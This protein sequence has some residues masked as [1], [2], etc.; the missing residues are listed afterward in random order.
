MLRVDGMH[1]SHD[2]SAVLRQ[3]HEFDQASKSYGAAILS[4]ERF[5]RWITARG[6]DM[7][8]VEAR[9]DP[10]AFGKTSPISYFSANFVKLLED[11]AAVLT[12]HFFCGQHSASNDKLCGPRGLIRSLQAQLV[13]KWP[14]DAPTDGINITEELD[15][16]HETFQTE[17]FC[18]LFETMLA[19]IPSHFTIIC[20]IDDIPRL[21]RG[22]WANDFWVLMTMLGNLVYQSN[23]GLARLKLLMTSPTRSRLLQDQIPEQALIELTEKGMFM[24]DRAQQAVWRSAKSG[25]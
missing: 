9:L 4:N 22:H 13:Q 11:K 12:L 17:R 20:V 1:D 14:Q 16:S 6:P 15:Y 8:Y 25:L 2:L 7:I 19:H 21:E 5:R 24:G 18:K 23:P 3:S 10:S